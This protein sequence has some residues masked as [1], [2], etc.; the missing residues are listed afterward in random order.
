M[1]PREIPLPKLTA[2]EMVLAA[3][4]MVTMACALLTR[5]QQIY[6]DDHER[7]KRYIS[8]IRADA[9]TELRGQIL[10]NWEID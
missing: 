1:S 3:D 4:E 6:A 10:A 2:D 9:C 5:A 7:T 8:G